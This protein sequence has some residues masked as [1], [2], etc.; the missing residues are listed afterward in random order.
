MKD[1]NVEV[2]IE[3]LYFRERRN[4]RNRI[5][6]RKRDESQIEEMRC[7]DSDFPSA[8]QEHPNS[9]KTSLYPSNTCYS[10]F[11]AFSFK[12]AERGLAGEIL[13]VQHPST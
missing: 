3:M 8:L 6:E 9:S 2:R 5:L 13:D 12:T 1:E 7:S 11:L 4:R 10:P